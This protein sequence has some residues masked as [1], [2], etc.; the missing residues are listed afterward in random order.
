MEVNKKDRNKPYRFT[1]N[2]GVNEYVLEF[3]SFLPVEPH[4]AVFEVP[5]VCEAHEFQ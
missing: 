1:I 3:A 4:P 2:T 5:T